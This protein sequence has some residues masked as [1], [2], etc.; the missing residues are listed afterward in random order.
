[1]IHNSLLTFMHVDLS[2]LKHLC[3]ESPNQFYTCQVK[4]TIDDLP[5]VA[6]ASET[7]RNMS[8]SDQQQE[9]S[10]APHRVVGAPNEAALLQLTEKTGYQMIQENGQ[11]KYE[12]P[13]D[14][15]VQHH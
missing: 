6:Q 13:A 8:V 15:K 3:I 14:G 10:G 1:M 9:A 12:P 7:F 2:A 11:R 4:M 5:L